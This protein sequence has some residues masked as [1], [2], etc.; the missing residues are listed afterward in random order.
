[1][2]SVSDSFT[3]ADGALGP[4]WRV[5]ANSA[6]FTTGW[7][8]TPAGN[9]AIHSN[10]AGGD[11][12]NGLD[13][14]AI[15][16]GGQSFANNQQAQAVI[17]TIAAPTGIL[18]ITAASQAGGNTTYTYTVASG[19][20]AAA[21]AGGFLFVIISGMSD[22]GNNGHFV[23]TTFGA[24]TFTVANASGVSNPTQTGTGYCPSDCGMGVGVRLSGT[25]RANINGYFFHVGTNSFGGGGR[26]FYYELWKVINGA[27]TI[28]MAAQEMP[29]SQ[30]SPVPGDVM[31]ITAIGGVITAYYNGV[32]LTGG[33]PAYGNNGVF[34]FSDSL[35]A[36]GAPGIWS[37]A[38]SGGSEYNF[39]VWSSGS[40]QFGG[41][42][43][44]TINNFSANDI[45]TGGM[46]LCVQ[47]ASAPSNA[48]TLAFPANNAAGNI[49]ICQEL[50][51][52]VQAVPVTPTDTQ[53]NV[54]ATLAS[55]VVIAG[56]GTNII[57]LSYALNSKAGPNTVNI[58]GQVGGFDYSNIAEFSA[59]AA[60]TLDNAGVTNTN[61]AAT[62]ISR[63]IST[64]AGFVL[65]VG[66]LFTSGSTIPSA[67][68]ISGLTSNRAW[69]F[70]SYPSTFVIASAA[71]AGGTYATGF[72]VSVADIN[73]ISLAS[74]LLGSTVP[75]S[76]G[77]D[78]FGPGFDFNFRM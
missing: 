11:A 5:I 77:G 47:A 33:D 70:N 44:T 24:N 61:T 1:M 75:P 30:I 74:F 6:E 71:G 7:V 63:L 20:V 22:G 68:A 15:W 65:V 23:S 17:K 25:T 14:V 55:T 42:S 18:T 34:Q 59:N 26:K 51:G 76:A 37:F 9:I 66:G 40:T 35:V 54:W 58:G 46:N 36:S 60:A 3:R 73:A 53:G 52:S 67:G 13:C 39:A 29:L 41:G 64:A 62:S 48:G 16:A 2:A 78:D 27:G 49:L 31:G 10:G 56:G 21:I 32:I 38:V 43:G 4:N 50:Y 19:S 69:Q 8:G 72:T 57:R 45:K 12:T 28:F